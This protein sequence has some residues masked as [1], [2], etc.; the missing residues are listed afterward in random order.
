MSRN[1][2]GLA[3]ISSECES[4]CA[5]EPDLERRIVK[6]MRPVAN[7]HWMFTGDEDLCFRGAIGGVLRSPQTTEEEKERLIASV[8]GL[9]TISA[10]LSGVPV[11]LEAAMD[12][13][14]SGP[15]VI[16]LQKLW[17]EAKQG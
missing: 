8:E 1:D 6:A 10:I 16:P 9:R 11:D 3:I 13:L 5:N 17:L 14:N 7:G 4:A 15:Q 12:K 2:A